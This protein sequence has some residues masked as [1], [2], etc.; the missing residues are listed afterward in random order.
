MAIVSVFSLLDY[1][2]IYLCIPLS[3]NDNTEIMNLIGATGNDE[4]TGN[5]Y[6][7]VYTFRSSV[8]SQFGEYLIRARFKG[9]ALLAVRRIA[10]AQWLA[11]VNETPPEFWV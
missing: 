3:V 10:R 9:I 2:F 1:L 4:N 11:T 8:L 5:L 7:F 6:L